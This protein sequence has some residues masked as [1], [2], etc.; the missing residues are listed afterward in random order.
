MTRPLEVVSSHDHQ[1]D[2]GWR[3]SNARALEDDVR[4]ISETLHHLATTEEL[5]EFRGKTQTCTEVRAL[6]ALLRSIAADLASSARQ[7][8]AQGIEP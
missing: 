7:L 4:T 1:V 2:E 5:L 6:S 3:S 8:R